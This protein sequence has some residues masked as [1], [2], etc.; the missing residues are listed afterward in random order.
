MNKTSSLTYFQ[1]KLFTRT[2][3]RIS[4][5][6]DRTGERSL[7]EAREHRD[8]Q[9]RLK[10]IEEELSSLTCAVELEVTYL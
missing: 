5:D 1:E 6:A 3:I 9:T 8:L 10:A 2:N 4:V 7:K